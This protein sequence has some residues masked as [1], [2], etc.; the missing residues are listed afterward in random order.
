MKASCIA[1]FNQKGGV[2]KTT[3]ALN[4]GAA[5]ARQQQDVLLV[6]LDPQAHL[7][8]IHSNTPFNVERSIFALYQ[9]SVSLATLA[10]EWPAI[11]YLIPAHGELIKVDSLF[12]KGPNI[13]NRLKLGLSDH[14]GK[15][16]ALNVIVDCCPFLGVLSLNAVFAADRML[17]PISSDFLSLRGAFQ[18]ERT[19]KALEPV[20][21]RRIERRYLL[22]RFDRRR[23]MSYEIQDR[24]RERFGNELCETVISENVT[25][26]EAPS[27]NLDIFRHAPNSR[28]AQDYAA[29][30]EELL[31]SGF[32]AD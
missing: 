23:K 12:G 27:L 3:T 15:F 9:H 32:L 26:A 10:V 19:L 14:L 22:T 21:K 28:G 4:L 29:L 31:T 6:D 8:A 16:P 24:L 20:L 5:M 17:V 18:I 11:G 2:G 30:L 1:V 7:S 13:L 25:V